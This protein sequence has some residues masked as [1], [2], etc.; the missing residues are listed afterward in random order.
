MAK[1]ELDNVKM[2]E[3]IRNGLWHW[4]QQ[5]W[6]TKCIDNALWE[7]GFEFDKDGH[8]VSIKE[9]DAD[10]IIEEGKWYMCLFNEGVEEEFTT[11]K[12]YQAIRDNVLINDK[13]SISLWSNNT[14]KF[15]PAKEEEIPQT[16]EDIAKTGFLDQSRPLLLKAEPEQENSPT[17]KELERNGKDEFTEFEK[18]VADCCIRYRLTT[19][20]TFNELIK[21]LSKVLLSSARKQIESEERLGI[22]KK[23]F[24]E[25]LEHLY[26]YADEVVYNRGYGNGTEDARKQFIEEACDWLYDVWPQIAESPQF[27]EDFRKALEKGE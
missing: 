5:E 12:V 8:I 7:H 18:T 24:E 17:F 20:G 2:W 25:E 9:Q 21:D 26:T 10:C 19:E 11:G 14:S 1:I 4:P 23:E 3:S 27:I 16:F 6:L 13:L 22:T 15:R